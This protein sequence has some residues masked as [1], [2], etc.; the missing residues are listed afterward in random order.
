MR[1][2]FTLSLL[3]IATAT[4]AQES[5]CNATFFPSGTIFPMLLAN[6]AE[7][8]IGLQKE[9]NTSHLKIGV[10]NALDVIEF[11][12][13]E[14]TLRI[15]IDFFIFARTQDF[16]NTRLAVDVV[17]GFF[18]GHLTYHDA[19]PLSY[20]FRILHSGSHYADGHYDAAKGEWQDG[21]NPIKYFRDFGELVARYESTLA[22]ANL[23]LYSG[24]SYAAAKKPTTLKSVGSLHGV[25][26]TLP[27][28]PRAYLAY[29]LTL[30]GV[31]QYVG[32]SNAELGLRF[33][34]WISQGAR[35]YAYYNSGL[36]DFGQYYDRRR[37]H[38]GL[39][40]AFDFL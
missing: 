35:L 3:I 4:H 9:I 12:N 39:G 21:K 28:S 5:R 20:R 8:R 16:G 15:G 36:D 37:T 2:L 29:N 25:Q 10:G 17:D 11:R 7:P 24:V 33:G 14:N 6:H 30:T 31:P 32:S 13:E 19:G 22:G 23:A 1:F 40:F 34:R 18:G 27:S 38:W 26:I